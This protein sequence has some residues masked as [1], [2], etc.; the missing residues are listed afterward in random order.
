M[1]RSKATKIIRWLT[2]RSNRPE[3][4]NRS[5]RIKF[6]QLRDAGEGKEFVKALALVY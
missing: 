2:R 1:A 4:L 3:S 5:P 6:S